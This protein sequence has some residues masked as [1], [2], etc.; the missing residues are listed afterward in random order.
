MDKTRPQVT[1]ELIPSFSLNPGNLNGESSR[2][3]EVFGAFPG[4]IF[5]QKS[6]HQRN[7]LIVLYYSFLSQVK[8]GVLKF[9]AS[10]LFEPTDVLC[11]FI[12]ATGDTRHRYVIIHR[13]YYMAAH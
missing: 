9:L 11:H 2:L 8:L 7:N 13:G 1:P 6:L 3:S 4:S 5:F 10:D 12:V